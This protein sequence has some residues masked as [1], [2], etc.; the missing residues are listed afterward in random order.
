MKAGKQAAQE[1]VLDL[2]K[3]RQSEYKTLE[4][5]MD[6][7]DEAKAANDSTPMGS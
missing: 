4:V 3:D 7:A 1:F 5:V 6:V 2:R